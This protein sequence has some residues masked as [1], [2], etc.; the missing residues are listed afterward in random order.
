M[1]WRI[2]RATPERREDAAGYADLVAGFGAFTLYPAEAGKGRLYSRA[3]YRSDDPAEV[4]ELRRLLAARPAGRVCMCP[5]SVAISLEGGGGAVMLTV[6]HRRTVR[7]PDATCGDLVFKRRHR[8][9]R[10][11]AARGAKPD[12]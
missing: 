5:G 3:A 1:R 11:L 12:R 6:H 4:A 2:D 10:W 9:T 8:L 7:W